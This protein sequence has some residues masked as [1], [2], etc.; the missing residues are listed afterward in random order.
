MQAELRA[1]RAELT[2]ATRELREATDALVQAR[3]QVE[4]AG[5]A[6][7]TKL[8]FTDRIPGLTRI[9]C[10]RSFR[11]T[12]PRDL[13]ELILADPNKLRRQATARISKKGGKVLGYRL[14]R[15]DD[16]SLP[17]AVGLQR[18]DIVERVQ[19]IALT[20]PA[21][22]DSAMK[23]MA[24]AKKITAVIKRGKKRQTLRIDVVD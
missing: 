14:D 11:C 6:K 4:G 21:A 15:V 8:A 10:S 3:K 9:K 16:G 13:V 7:S 1:A 18:G 20:T 12:V 19:T 5:A 2:E 17:H 23:K 22:F 24:K